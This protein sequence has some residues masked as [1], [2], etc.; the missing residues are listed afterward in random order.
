MPDAAELAQQ[1]L[2][3][4]LRVAVAESLTSGLVCSA[5][6][7]AERAAEWFAG[8]VVAYTVATKQRVLGVEPDVDP[9]S[10]QCAMQL[11]DGVRE[12]LGADIAVSTSGVGGP[13]ADGGHAPGTVYLGWATADDHGDHLLRL[14][15]SPEEVV[16]ETTR[17]AV[18]LLTVLA[19]GEHPAP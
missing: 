11:A 4:G 18:R 19:R 2:H 3:R 17:R 5:V 9:C 15:G 6:G 8:G 7:T 10:P 12:L 16:A 13:D 1:A 14:E